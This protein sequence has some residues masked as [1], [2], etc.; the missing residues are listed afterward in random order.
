MLNDKP[1][2]LESSGEARSLN[3][4]VDLGGIDKLQLEDDSEEGDQ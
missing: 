1:T 3:D 4:Y 2:K